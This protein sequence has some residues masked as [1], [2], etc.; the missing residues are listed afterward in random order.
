MKTEAGFKMLTAIDA[1]HHVTEG[2]AYP[3]VLLTTGIKDPRVSPWQS[4]KLAARLQ[5]NAGSTKPALLRVNF[6]D[7]HGIG[8]T[9]SQQQEELADTF[10]FL[11]WQAGK[12]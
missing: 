10:A 8:S 5:A 12:K 4:A 6:E 3:A 1:F 7:G 2:V 9:R 11:L